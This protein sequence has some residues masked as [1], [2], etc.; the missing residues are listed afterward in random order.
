MK[1]LLTNN[2]KA[3]A[4]WLCGILFLLVSVALGVLTGAAELSAADV[5][6]ALTGGERT[7]AA[8]RILFYVR[9]P[10]VCAALFCGAALAVS[11]AVIQGVLANHL[12]SP[13]MIG[14]NAGAGLAVTLCAVCGVL[15]GWR[16]S[17]AAFLG[18]FAC[19]LA[20]SAA[21]KHWG[22]TDGVVIL[23][24][25]ALNSLLGAFSDAVVAVNPDVSVMNSEFRAGDFSAVTTGTLLPAA[26][27]ITA[28]IAILLLLTNELDV[29]SLGE[30]NARGLGMQTGKMRVLF[31]LLSALLAGAA[32]SVAGLL[33][34][35]GLLV[36]HAVRRLAGGAANRL[37]PF[38]ALFGGAFTVLC[39]TAA[40]TLFAPYELPVG[41]FLS[42]L[43]APFFL[44]LLLRRRGGHHD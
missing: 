16:L 43:G 11:G 1:F 38:C 37:L 22:A 8:A 25:A 32:V 14:V 30:D 39:D 6:A 10:R 40:R 23:V 3:A 7:T 36:P 20:V 19:V 29:L 31:L 33:S 12:A 2:R 44:Y 27:A 24:G 28:A 17:L 18:A 9:I 15:G 41:I 35:V 13:G 21:A 5:L 34:F 42:F 4:L 26:I